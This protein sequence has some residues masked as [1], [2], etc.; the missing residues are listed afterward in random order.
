[1]KHEL[2]QRDFREVVSILFDRIT[3]SN[4]KIIVYSSSILNEYQISLMIKSI[5]RNT[6]VFNKL[7]K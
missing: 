1:M 2:G 3:I 7:V 4:E 5:D 6:V